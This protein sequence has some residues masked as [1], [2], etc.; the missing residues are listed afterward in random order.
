[1]DVLDLSSERAGEILRISPATVRVLAARG[2][3]TLAKDGV[4][5]MTDV[6][7]R[8]RRVSERLTPLDRA[9]ERLL[10]REARKRRCGRVA[11]A[12]VALVVASP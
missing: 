9:F 6:R 2:R 7:E 3:A 10:E 11:A 12:T 1:M 5:A 4:I 8:L